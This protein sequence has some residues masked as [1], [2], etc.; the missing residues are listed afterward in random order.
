MRLNGLLFA[1]RPFSDLDQHAT[2]D[3]VLA[4]HDSVDVMSWLDLILLQLFRQFL[5]SCEWRH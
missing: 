1:R 4:G 2:S 3:D 5:D